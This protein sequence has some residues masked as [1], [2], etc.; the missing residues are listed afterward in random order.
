M[1]TWNLSEHIF[2]MNISLFSTKTTKKWSSLHNYQFILFYL[3]YEEHLVE[4]IFWAV[5]FLRFR[6]IEKLFFVL[7]PLKFYEMIFFHWNLIP[8]EAF[9]PNFYVYFHLTRKNFQLHNFSDRYFYAFQTSLAC[10][11]LKNMQSKAK[12]RSNFFS[13]AILCIFYADSKKPNIL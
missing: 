1:L 5:K 13:F 12:F 2:F 4:N 3:H 6:T 7:R 9:T 10:L 11:N 8:W